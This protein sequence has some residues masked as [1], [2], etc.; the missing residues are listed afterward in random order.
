MEDIEG[1]YGAGG[2]YDVSTETVLGVAW[3]CVT[4]WGFVRSADAGSTA[5]AVRDVIRPPKPSKGNADYLLRLAEVRA[6]AG[7]MTEKAQA[8]RAWIASDEFNGHSDYVINLKSV[9]AAP[10]VSDRNYGLLVSAP[11]AWARFLEKSLIRKI[12]A[13]TRVSEHVGE[14]GE[15]W[16]LLLTVE[17]ERFIETAYGTSAL[18]KMRDDN[19]NL[20]SWFASIPVYAESGPLTAYVGEKVSLSAGIKRHAEYKGVF[21]TQLTRVKVIDTIETAA[22]LKAAPIKVK[23]E[24]RLTDLTVNQNDVFYVNGTYYR[25]RVTKGTAYAVKFTTNGWEYAPKAIHSLTVAMVV[26]AEDAAR[27]GK[28][29]HKCVYCGKALTDERSARVGYGET[30]AHTHGLPWGE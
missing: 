28:E 26:S 10:M 18:Y 24:M 21:E 19:G 15:R 22:M 16:A 3:A 6:L 29:F 17:S 9:A 14:I 4:T 13:D 25:I 11:Q 23:D 5:H 12:E 8:L 1:G 7:Q 30:C 2:G 20:F 27:F